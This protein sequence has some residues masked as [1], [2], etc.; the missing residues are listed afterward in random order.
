MGL[1]FKIALLES[2]IMEI[3]S[4]YEEKETGFTEQLKK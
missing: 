1:F 3:P 2:D 4:Y